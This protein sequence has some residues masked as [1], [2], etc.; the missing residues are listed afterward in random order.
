EQRFGVTHK[1]RIKEL[2]HNVDVLTLTATPIPRTLHMSLAGIRDMSLLREAPQ[3]R[4]P[5]Q[6]FV[7]EYSEEMVR[8]ALSREVARNGQ[9]YYVHNRVNDIADVAAKVQSLM[10]DAVVSFAHGQMNER[11]LEDIMV[12][13]INGDIDILVSTT[14]IETG[15][16][17]PN[18][19]T[20]IVDDSERMG[21]AQLY[22]LRGRVGRSN[23]MAYAFLMYRR[24]R[25]LKETAE[26]RL[27]AIKEFTDLGS[28]FKIAMKDLEIR[29]AGNVL[30]AEQSGHMAEVG[31][32]LYCKMLDSAVK[33][34]RGIEDHS[35]FST[36]IDMDIDALIPDSYIRNENMKL[37]MYKRIAR[38]SSDDEASDMRDE[39]TD[40]FGRI[41][42]GTDNLIEIAL[43]RTKAHELFIENIK[44]TDKDITMTIYMNAT[45]DPTNIAPMLMDFKGSMRFVTTGRPAFIYTLTAKNR[46]E[47]MIAVLRRV[48]GKMEPLIH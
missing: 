11:Q 35:D 29:G 26:K 20:I 24:D 22:Q 45:I 1:E 13:F 43:L 8:E 3:D 37:D 12:D 46:E 16:D 32:D 33:K 34:E 23:R 2:R 42:K 15:L 40:R 6:T 9:V 27:S 19:N 30:G 18:V 5:I 7:M 10:P 41:P 44:V 38:V 25:I 14:I 36:Y 21:L 39:L 17:I 31:Y 48:L 47:S 4:L 28:G